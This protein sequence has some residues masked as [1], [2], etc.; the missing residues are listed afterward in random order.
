MRRARAMILGV[1]L[2]WAAVANAQ[3]VA[4]PASMSDDSRVTRP[5]DSS[6]PL[7][8]PP[9]PSPVDRRPFYVGAG[10]LAFAAVFWWNR[11][12]REALDAEDRDARASDRTRPVGGD[13]DA[14]DLHAAASPPADP[15]VPDDRHD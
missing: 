7:D 14:D 6:P 3:R 8:A 4:S 15:E 13:A 5:L 11:K 9:P 12:Q 10:L 1:G 2:A